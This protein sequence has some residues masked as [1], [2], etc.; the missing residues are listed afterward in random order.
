MS[1]PKRIILNRRIVA[2]AWQ[3]VGASDAL[4]LGSPRRTCDG[5]TRRETL[6]TLIEI[7]LHG[8]DESKGGVLQ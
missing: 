5:V 4:P 3:L 6:V 8:G 1:Q 7:A 2:D